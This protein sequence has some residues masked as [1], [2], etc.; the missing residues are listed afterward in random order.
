MRIIYR[1]YPTNK[2]VLKLNNKPEAKSLL[3]NI[4]SKQIP[5]PVRMDANFILACKDKLIVADDQSN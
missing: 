3:S 1:M 4:R 2:L 5:I